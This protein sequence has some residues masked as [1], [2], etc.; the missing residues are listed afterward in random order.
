MNL[1]TDGARYY[2]VQPWF[3][4]EIV[5][6]VKRD[7]ERT[8]LKGEE[9]KDLCGNISFSIC[10]LID[11]T[12]GFEAD[13]EEYSSFLAFSA[14]EGPMFYP[15]GNSNLHEYVFGVLEQVFADDA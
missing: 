14:E 8:G 9:L 13:G 7:L 5:Q 11:S 10:S 2:K 15:G 6:A 3:V 4:G 12:A 1:E